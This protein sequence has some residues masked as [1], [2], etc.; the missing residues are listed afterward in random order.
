MPVRREA[1]ERYV[2]YLRTKYKRA[3]ILKAYEPMVGRI[4]VI[5]KQ[6][7]LQRDS[8]LECSARSCRQRAFC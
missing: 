7:E 8:D 5:G 3:D 6:G 1:W 2:A 4:S